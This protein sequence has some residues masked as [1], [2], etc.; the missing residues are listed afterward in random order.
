MEWHVGVAPEV[1]TGNEY[2]AINWL[3]LRA[4]LLQITGPSD[5]QK[6]SQL[7]DLITLLIQDFISFQIKSFQ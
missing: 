6:A 1:V 2:T 5:L 3:N 7:K 4:G